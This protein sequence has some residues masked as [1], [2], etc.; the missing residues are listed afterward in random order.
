MISAPT[1]NTTPMMCQ[2]AEIVLSSDVIPTLNRLSSERR[3]EHDRV[4]EED[5]LLRVRVVEPV[6]EEHGAE[7]REPVADRRR[8]GDLADQVEPAREPTP[9]RAAELRGPV[10]E[11]AGGRVGGCDLGHRERDDRAHEP[12]EQPAPRH[13]DRA[14]LVEGDVVRRQ[15]AREDRDDREADREV[16]EPAHRAEELLGVAR[17]CAGSARPPRCGS[18]QVRVLV[19]RSCRLPH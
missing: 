6:V 10:V 17:A 3:E 18:H 5:V 4:E 13:R 2:Y 16:L 11:A 8:D 19:S 7:R 14:A 15:A 9:G 12:D 1:M